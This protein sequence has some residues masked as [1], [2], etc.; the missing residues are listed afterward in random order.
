S[1]YEWTRLELCP[2]APSP[3]AP[4]HEPVEHLRIYH[5]PSHRPRRYVTLEEVLHDNIIK[6]PTA[7]VM[8]STW[9]RTPDALIYVH[10]LL[11][12]WYFED[13]LGTQH[14]LAH[15]DV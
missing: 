6:K 7:D 8:A 15:V 4:I 13:V 5:D 11:T 3:S 1:R 10:L 2:Q 14:T 9:S 12:G